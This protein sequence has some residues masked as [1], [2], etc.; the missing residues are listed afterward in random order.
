MSSESDPRKKAEGPLH[1]FGTAKIGGVTCNKKAATILRI[2][3]EIPPEKI[4][5]VLQEL[6]LEATDEFRAALDDLIGGLS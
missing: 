6:N 3:L 4:K 5:D 1:R 2:D